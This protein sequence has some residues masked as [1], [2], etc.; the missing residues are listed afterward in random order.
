MRESG[1]I[2]GGNCLLRPRGRA[3]VRS[4]APSLHHGL[5]QVFGGK[6][7]LRTN[8]MRESRMFDGLAFSSVFVG[9][10]TPPEID[11]LSERLEL[12]TGGSSFSLHFGP[13][14]PCEIPSSVTLTVL[15]EG[16]TT[17]VSAI[18]V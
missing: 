10:G 16:L 1:D 7:H 17:S 13:E 15:L 9:E 18:V 6:V 4:E 3:T 14:F 5:A 8:A 12:L 11:L 2:A